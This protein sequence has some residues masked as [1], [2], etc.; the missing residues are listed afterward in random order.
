MNYFVYAEGDPSPLDIEHIINSM[1]KPCS[2][3]K[4]LYMAGKGKA[5]GV[6]YE[7][8]VKWKALNDLNV[9]IKLVTANDLPL[10]LQNLI[11]CIEFYCS[12]EYIN[13]LYKEGSTDFFNSMGVRYNTYTL[14]TWD[15]IL[16]K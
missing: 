14:G 1:F 5:I 7:S 15:K 11:D 2:L 8:A 12:E 4:D 6:A 10:L 16:T 9:N 3:S 13:E